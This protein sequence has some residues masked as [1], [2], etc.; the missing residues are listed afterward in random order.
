[1]KNRQSIFLLLLF[2]GFGVFQSCKD[3]DSDLNFLDGIE[4]PSNLALQVELSQDNS[5]TVTFTPT[6]N[7]ASLFIVDFGDGS[8]IAEVQPGNST[9]NVYPEGAYTVTLNA[10]NINGELGDP[11]EV[12]VVVS[13]LPPQNISITVS[14]VAG[15]NF[16]IELSASADFA[17]GFEVYF[18]DILDEEPTSLALNSSVIHTY[19]EVGTYEV[20][21][22]AL[23]GGQETSSANE[24]V[25]IENPLLLP[26]DFES[27]TLD[28]NFINF[29][30]GESTLIDNPDPSGIN[31]SSKVAQFF[32]EAGAEIFAGSV[33]ELGGLIDFS[34]FQSFKMDVW[35]PLVGSTVKLKIENAFDPNISAEI[36]AITTTS[37]A[38]ETLYFDFSNQDLSQEYAKIVVF[39]DFG[40]AGNDDTFYYDNI[41][42]DI[43]PGGEISLPLTFENSNANYNIIGFEGAESEIEPN[44]DPSGVNTTLNVVRTTKTV[45]AQFFAGTAIP[46]DIPIEFGTTERIKMKTWSPKAGIPV[47]LKLENASG[48]FVELDVNTTVTNQ[49]EELVWDFT[50]MNTSPEFTTV[51]VFF[52]FVVDLPGDGST[53]YFDEIEFDN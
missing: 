6:G 37:G 40:N 18:G 22:V 43:L 38:W 44:P 52:E 11:I 13:F 45:G 29:G 16:S 2:L 50:G 31:T 49:W 25:L 34:E 35:S 39:F 28:Y 14:P 32:K 19:P 8:E 47:R 42:Q 23:S 27:E 51:V 7:S 17:V 5:G 4:L 1:M 3:D 36:D 26:I 33:I 12:P 24:T 15:D 41:E 30:G 9:S 20:T 48:E 53:Y 10:Q 21:V 46:L